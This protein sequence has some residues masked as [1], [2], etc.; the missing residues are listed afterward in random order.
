[1]L[2]SNYCGAYTT[3]SCIYTNSRRYTCNSRGKSSRL[4]YLFIKNGLHSDHSIVNLELNNNKLN[5]GKG[6]WKL[7]NNILHVKEY[8]NLITKTISE[9]KI[10]LNQHT[11]KG[12]VWEL[13][14]LQIRSV[15]IPYCI[16]KIKNM[17]SFKNNLIKEINLK[18]NRTR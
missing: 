10:N 13:I 12:L 16:K 15:S 17:D 4:D 2:N 11:D 3:L 6:V 7:N 8:V 18:R 14:K 9:C 1:M 5:R